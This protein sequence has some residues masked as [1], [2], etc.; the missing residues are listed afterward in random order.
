MKNIILR[1]VLLA[2]LLSQSLH[3]QILEPEGKISVDRQ[4][5]RVG[6]LPVLNWNI[7]YPNIITEFVIHDPLDEGETQKRTL[8]EVRVLGSASKMTLNGQQQWKNADLQIQLNSGTYTSIFF[9]KQPQVNAGSVVFS[10]ILEKGTTINMRA[11]NNKTSFNNWNV[12]RATGVTTYQNNIVALRHGDVP[13]SNV[14]ANDQASIKDFLRP[15]ISEG[16]IAIGPQDVI[17]LFELG[18]DIP[19]PNG[20]GDMQDMVVLHTYKDVE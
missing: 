13:P 14:P 10:Q 11:R 19:N 4:F 9:G 6:A 16:K 5:A 15:Y 18:W 7:T 3:S 2:A 8:L 12:W 1:S 17:Y 20:Y